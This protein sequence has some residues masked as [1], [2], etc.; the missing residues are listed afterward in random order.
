M[1][2][3]NV[4]DTQ[5]KK[6]WANNYLLIFFLNQSNNL[7]TKSSMNVWYSSFLALFTFAVY[8]FSLPS[9][10]S[11]F[12]SSSLLF[13][14]FGLSRP[15]NIYIFFSSSVCFLSVLLFSHPINLVW[16]PPHTAMKHEHDFKIFAQ[17]KRRNNNHI[18]ITKF[19][20]LVLPDFFTTCTL[21]FP[22]GGQSKIL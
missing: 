12:S 5:L 9:S 17:T 7:F 22:Q 16:A 4:C 1:E 20:I 2:F 14:Y 15:K 21:L 10:S 18:Q 6:N 8:I 3:E 11:S 13:I 19:I